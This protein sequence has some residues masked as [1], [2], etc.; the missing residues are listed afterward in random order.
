MKNL[1]NKLCICAAVLV[2]TTSCVSTQ[3]VTETRR[4]PLLASLKHVVPKVEPIEPAEPI[5]SMHPAR[6]AGVLLERAIVAFR[7]GELGNASDDFTRAIR[8]GRLNDAGR[9]LAYW[10][11]FL[12]EK[13][14]GNTSVSSDA[15]SSFVVVAADLV[16]DRA[17]G[18]EDF[19]VRFDLR[20]KLARARATLSAN[21]AN[22]SP[23]FGRTQASAVPV[24]SAQEMHYFLAL[25][26]PCPSLRSQDVTQELLGGSFQAI[27]MTCG[28]ADGASSRYFFDVDR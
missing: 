14:M 19:V 16:A 18:V 20:G 7:A 5:E 23:V 26:S 11:V 8:T 3:T 2:S 13:Q 4:G 27:T 21:W 12:A 1:L 6:A 15:L 10:H 17:G 24:R 22:R 9:S 25:V 28:G